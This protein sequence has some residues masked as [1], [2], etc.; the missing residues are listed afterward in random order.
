MYP[1]LYKG[2]GLKEEDLIKY[3]MP[4]LGFNEK[5]VIPTDQIKIPVVM[6]G[7]E[8]MV[9]FIVVHAFSLYQAILALPWIHAVGAILLSCIEK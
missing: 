2:L 1:D 9:N 5:M 3:D 6:D 7:K 8:V 4:L